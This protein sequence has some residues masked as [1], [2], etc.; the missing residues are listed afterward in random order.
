MGVRPEEQ[1][2]IW[3]ERGCTW[4]E[5]SLDHERVPALEA[6]WPRRLRN[7]EEHVIAARRGANGDPP[8]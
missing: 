6:A 3:L 8:R 7:S 5:S 2:V 1:D 4:L